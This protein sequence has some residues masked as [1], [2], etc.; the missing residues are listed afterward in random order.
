[1]ENS[2]G[3]SGG[4][5][6][7]RKAR[8]L[9]LQSLYKSTVSVKQDNN[10]SKSGVVGDDGEARKKRR[11]SRKEVSLSSLER[12]GEKSR[13]S[14]GEVYGDG[15]KSDSAN[16]GKLK[17]G[18]SQN[19]DSSSGFNSI[20]LSLNDSANVIR[21]PKRRRGF[22]GRS[23]F[24][25]NQVLR[26]LGTSSGR[27]GGSVEQTAKANGECRKFKEDQVSKS[28]GS[29]DGNA[30]SANQIAKLTDDS[31]GKII[32][33]KV[34]GKTGSD[35]LKENRTSRVNSARRLN[36]RKRKDLAFGS[37]SLAKKVEP[38]A[39]SSK[40]IRD[41]SQDED[42]EN[43]EQNAARMLSSR[44]DPSCTGFPSNSSFL[45]SPSTNGSSFFAPFGRGADSLT[46]LELA[47]ADS[48]CRILRPRK[49]H[50]EK[51]FRKRRHF[52]E[53]LFKDLDAYWMLNRKIKVFWPLDESWY[54]GVVNNYD[55]ER[56]L[57]H[58]KYD[59]RD[60]E[61]ISLQ[62]ERFKLLLFPSE[63]PRKIE[64][65]RETTGDRHDN[66]GKGDLATDDDCL[67]GSYMDSE[68][69]ISWLASARRVKASLGDSKRL[70]TLHITSTSVPLVL[71]TKTNDVHGSLDMGSSERDVNKSSNSA[72]AD[73]FIDTRRAKKSVLEGISISTDSKSPVVY[74][75]RRF[76]K[77]DKGLFDSPDGNKAQGGTPVSVTSI[78]PIVHGFHTY[79]VYD[80]SLGHTDSEG[81]LWSVDNSGLLKLTVRLVE[82]KQ[83]RFELGSAVPVPRYVG[84]ENSW[85]LRT[86]LL[87]HY[88]TVTTKCS[89]IR[90]EMLF[91]DNFVG[92]R[93]LVFEGCLKQAVTFIFLVLTVF[94]QPIE[95]RK[96]VDMQMPVTSIRCK[97]SSI[98][99]FKKQY[100]FAFHS[101]S[102]V[103]KSKWLYLD[104][105]LQEHC[106]FMKQ[107][108]LSECTYDNIKA[109]EGGCNYTCS[110]DND[111]STFEG[112]RKKPMKDIL[113]IGA[114]KE[115][116]SVAMNQSSSNSDVKHKLFLPF[117]L[118]F[119]AAPT[120]YLSL[121]LKLLMDKSV[122]CISLRDHDSMC[123]LEHSENTCPVANGCTVI[124]DFPGSVSEITSEG[125]PETSSR[126]AE[127]SERLLCAKSQSGIDAISECNGVGLVNSSQNNGN[128]SNVGTSACSRDPGENS[129]DVIE[130]SQKSGV[131]SLE[132]GKFITTPQLMVSKDHVSMGMSDSR[133][134]SSLTGLHVEIPLLDQI[135]RLGDGKTPSSTRSSDL[136][137]NMSDAIIRSPNPTGPRTIWHHNRNSLSS[138]FGDTSP[139][140]PNGKTHFIHNGFGNGPKKPR[141]Q[142]QY[143]LPSDVS[144]FSSKHKI[145]S[146]RGF[147]YRRIRKANEKW[148]SNN[149]RNS[150]RNL[151]FLACDANVLITIGDRGWRES[152]SRVVLELADHNEWKLAVKLTGGTKYSYKAH[153]FLQPG[154]TNRYTHAMM[155]K[156]GKD[157]VLE[158]PDRS[159]WMLF[160]EM[161]E[162]CYNRNL[163]AAS[164]KNI[165]IP[166]VRLIEESDDNGIELSFIRSSPAYFEQI[167]TDVDIAMDSSRILYDMDSDD[168]QWISLNK[169]EKISE[170]LFEKTMDMFEKVAYSQQRDSFTSDEIEKLMVEVGAMEAVKVIHKHWQLKRQRK[171]MPLIRHLQPP[172][173]E[174]YEQQLK[175]WEHAMAKVKPALSDGFREKASSME[176]PPLFAFCL[177]PRGLEVP[178]K[179]SKQRS[180]RKFPV[181]GHSHTVQGDQDGFHAFG[182]R[183]NGF[184]FGDE[185]FMYLGNGHDSSDA[186][187]SFQT[188]RVFSPQD[189]SGSAYFSLSNDWS[190]WNHPK[191]HRNK[192]KNGTFLSRNSPQMVPSYNQRPIG[193]KNGVHRWNMR[194]PEWPS[195]KH[196][197]LEGSLRHGIEQLDG[198]EL[199]EFRLRDA[200]GAAQH[201][202]NMAKL[203]REKAQ[204][205]LYR[206]DLAIH[207]AV[208]AL[209]TADAV[210]ASAEESNGIG[211]SD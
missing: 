107:L 80:I 86:M 5:E 102:K 63:I 52:Y 46:G 115:S 139:L 90:L 118:S 1:M 132:P 169:C 53:I 71:S 178:H 204:R 70:K 100:V 127:S 184:A 88:G 37:E 8:S 150:H 21:I 82:S 22:V 156:G 27:V 187:P 207:K 165:P 54:Y 143:T 38:L 151:E 205:L 149:S 129:R 36:H 148:T 210:K 65:K 168:E 177:K 185:K 58:I 4:T 152:G 24:E 144:D 13:N 200:S 146:Q 154:S 183:S 96:H 170:E 147:P 56:N 31:A 34:K 171:G 194:L 145:H 166:G 131:N 17:S 28:L 190:E 135:E 191:L 68:P 44:F 12:A 47:S 41:S 43:L 110:S 104:C 39:N 45:G 85:L 10:K 121:H 116:C 40:Y 137:W 197:Q 105:K 174:R 113:P 153:Q 84:S 189:A 206:A 15:S 3:K 136:V 108:P 29:S 95:Q 81:L 93:F 51:G 155:W 60:E 199:D 67:I 76:H 130:L 209:M 158:F 122:A 20:S 193:K 142:V 164:V 176:K 103:K 138:S 126:E 109:L 55:P 49:S 74:F 128:L 33:L 186:S 14:L 6:I 196:Y 181:S 175:E 62:N 66:N 92:L 172:L 30:S 198:L 162:E 111:P 87:L 141:T 117:G 161:H 23:K 61:W 73:G 208:V 7:S 173:W 11:K 89:K 48:D 75:R 160:K 182:R 32:F 35:D 77:K 83:F 98:E 91:V 134:Y 50:R 69:I 106:F 119:S 202:L 124:Q 78:A 133:I 64:T 195:Q 19:L 72:F 159:Q 18:L 188:S 203:K 25:T 94:Y 114:F 125:Y 59:D 211:D 79:N 201:A 57:H 123:S 179:G 16:S 157:W 97:L 192:S 180:H 101:F 140:W 120:I 167:E 99:N 2:G 112:S 163:R 9:D 42:E 26:S